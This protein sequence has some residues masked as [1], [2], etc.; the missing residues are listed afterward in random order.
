MSVKNVQNVVTLLNA[1]PK[2]LGV[3]VKIILYLRKRLKNWAKSTIIA[4]VS[5]V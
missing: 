4:Y 5:Y 1:A 3:G 2:A